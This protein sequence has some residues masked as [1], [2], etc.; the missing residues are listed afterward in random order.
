[1]TRR[2][3]KEFLEKQLEILKDYHVEDLMKA[4]RVQ[5]LE[6]IMKELNF[7]PMQEFCDEQSLDLWD[8]EIPEGYHYE[9]VLYVS[10]SGISDDE[11][12]ENY[13]DFM[14]MLMRTGEDLAE[15]I[16][17]IMKGFNLC[18]CTIEELLFGIQGYEEE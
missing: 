4:G 2:E 9:L 5:E 18:D 6:D 11:F 8:S 1:M 14:D 15:Q 3:V 7:S 16:E 10:Q 17:D 12:F 13:G